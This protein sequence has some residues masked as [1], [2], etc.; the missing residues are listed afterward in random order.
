MPYAESK[1]E[2]AL[3]ALSPAQRAA[4][5]ENEAKAATAIEAQDPYCACAAL[6]KVVDVRERALGPWHPDLSKTLAGPGPRAVP[7]PRGAFKV[8]FL[9]AQRR[10]RACS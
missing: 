10:S 4:I 9:C 6:A 8:R 2:S 1:E 7:K 5:E 3:V